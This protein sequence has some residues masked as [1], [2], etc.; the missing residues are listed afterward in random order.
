VKAILLLDYKFSRAKRPYR[1]HKVQA[2]IYALL[3]ES[4]GFSTEELCLGIVLFPQAGFGY[5]FQDTASAKADKLRSFRAD[6]TLRRIYESCEQ[7]RTALLTGRDKPATIKS[8]SW[9]A[10]LY[11]YNAKKAAKDLAW[12]LEYWTGVREP[13]PQEDRPRKCFACPMNAVRLCEHALDEPDPGFRVQRSPDGQ[14]SVFH[15]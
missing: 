3:A 15:E 9:N 7:A 13:I 8:E 2:E 12:A 4:M 11:R 10:F 14:I 5:G 1:N 6:G